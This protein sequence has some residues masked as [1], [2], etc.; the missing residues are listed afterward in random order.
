MSSYKY[1]R[2]CDEDTLDLGDGNAENAQ[3]FQD[4]NASIWTLEVP[5]QDTLEQ[6]V[7]DVLESAGHVEGSSHA[8]TAS[9]NPP[10]FRPPEPKVRHDSCFVGHFKR[11][12]N[13]HSRCCQMHTGHT[14]SANGAWHEEL[15]FACPCSIDFLGVDFW[16]GYCTYEA[17]P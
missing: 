12:A 4:S 13:T 11:L 2:G 14:T 9:K 7:N 3:D 8:L 17:K 10:V 1:T 16:R 5:S 6:G 15:R